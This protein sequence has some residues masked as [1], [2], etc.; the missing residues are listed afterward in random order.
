[1][2]L[3]VDACA[4]A[5]EA[6]AYMHGPHFAANPI[7]VEY[8]PEEA[9]ARLR[10]GDAGCRAVGTRGRPAGLAHPLDGPGLKRVEAEADGLVKARLLKPVRADAT[11]TAW[12]ALP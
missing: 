1:M 6:N 10:A 11:F 5:E 7:G 12:Q 4:T 9:L 2:E 3:Q 8:D